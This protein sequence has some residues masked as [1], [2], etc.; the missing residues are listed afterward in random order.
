MCGAR[1]G[2]SVEGAHVFV[3]TLALT[4]LEPDEAS[5][6][7]R[8][9]P[10]ALIGPRGDSVAFLPL[11]PANPSPTMPSLSAL[12]VLILAAVLEAGGDA[13]VRTGLHA[14]TAPLSLGLI[15]AGGRC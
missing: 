8:L 6:A 4:G 7:N 3:K 1:P 15:V 5:T 2:G 11:T 13:V 9:G 14:K 10:P 12:L